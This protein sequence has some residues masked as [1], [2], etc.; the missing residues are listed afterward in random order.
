MDPR[1][2][3]RRGDG[4]R[5]GSCSA[6]QSTRGSSPATGRG[7]VTYRIDGDGCEITLIE[8]DPTGR[9]TGST[10][11]AAVVAAARAAGCAR[12]WLVTTND[13]LGAIAWYERRG[14]AVA[15]VREGAVDEARATLKPTIPTHNAAKRAADQR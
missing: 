6:R 10:L 3:G 11:L 5:T 1:T 2:L 13:N 14:F 12:V 8:A 9:G 4:R 7:C 15:A